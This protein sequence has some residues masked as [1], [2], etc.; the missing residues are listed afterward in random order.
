MNEETW[1]EHPSA[2]TLACYVDRTLA[3]EEQ[4]GIEEHLS[5]CSECRLVVREAA[6]ALARR[7]GRLFARV[8]VG[9]AIGLVAAVVVV[10]LL[11]TTDP[12]RAAP[13]I[14]APSASGAVETVIPVI[15]PA[16]QASLAEGPLSFMWGSVGPGVRYRLSLS[17]P[18]GREVWGAS[19]EDTVVRLPG[20]VEIMAGTT[21]VWF[22]DALLSDGSSATT[23]MQRLT[24]ER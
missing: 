15:A 24:I 6:D 23:S 17:T 11:P 20:D 7:R 1:S 3:P 4:R 19:L 12:D 22:V 8:G 13:V 10:A 14:R 16:E 5:R 21:Y 2:S 18:D 9:A